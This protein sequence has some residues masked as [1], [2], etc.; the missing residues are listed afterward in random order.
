MINFFIFNFNEILCESYITVKINKSGRY[1]IIFTGSQ[2]ENNL[3]KNAPIHTPTSMTI[4]GNQTN[5]VGEYEFTEQENTIKLF[6]SR[7]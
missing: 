5:F 1:N 4:N 2:D 6:F 7:F 3:C